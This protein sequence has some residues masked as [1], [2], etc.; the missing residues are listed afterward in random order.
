MAVQFSPHPMSVFALPRES[1]PS[2]IRVEL[3][4]KREQTFPTL[5]IVI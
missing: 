2:E 5:L 3:C 4:K 1:K